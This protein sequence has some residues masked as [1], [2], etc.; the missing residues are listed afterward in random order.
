MPASGLLTISLSRLP[1]IGALLSL[2]V[3][4]KARLLSQ[5]VFSEE[6][7]R[8]V[9][10]ER[11]VENGGRGGIEHSKTTVWALTVLIS[12]T[13]FFSTGDSPSSFTR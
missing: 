1:D 7:S 11:H 12:S 2:R 4:K 8:W 10:R 13:I 3:L 5:G 9:E 6:T